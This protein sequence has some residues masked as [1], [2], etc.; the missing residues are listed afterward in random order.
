MADVALHSTKA[1]AALLPL[2]DA[3][4]EMPAPPC[5]G[6]PN[7]ERCAAESLACLTYLEYYRNPRG[8]YDADGL[9]GPTAAIYGR[10]FGVT[11]G[12]GQRGL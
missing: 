8:R 2:V 6:C 4:K 12:P 9:R 1:S 7:A 5:D 11:P 3:I 10:A